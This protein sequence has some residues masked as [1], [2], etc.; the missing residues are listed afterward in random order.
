MAS[1]HPSTAP[2]NILVAPQPPAEGIKRHRSSLNGPHLPGV[3][4][5]YG[6]CRASQTAPTAVL[7]QQNPPLAPV[8]GWAHLLFRSALSN[9]SW[10]TWAPS[11][12]LLWHL[13][14]SWAQSL[15]SPWI[16]VLTHPWEA[17]QHQQNTNFFVQTPG[18]AAWKP[19]Q[20]FFLKFKMSFSQSHFLNRL[21]QMTISPLAT[22]LKNEITLRDMA[23]PFSEQVLIKGWEREPQNKTGFPAHSRRQLQLF[24]ASFTAEWRGQLL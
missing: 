3:H 1:S 9:G 22:A 24:E 20:C 7:T 16:E 13:W 19:E 6:S 4:S 14:C 21:K 10:D 12:H 17:E 11:R 15:K 2:S 8:L 18:W 23:L 5:C